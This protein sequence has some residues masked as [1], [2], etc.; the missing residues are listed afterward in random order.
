MRSIH[1]GPITVR[2]DPNDETVAY[3]ANSDDGT[4][5]VV[6]LATNAITD[7]IPVAAGPWGLAFHPRDGTVYIN[8]F[9]SDTISVIDI[10]TKTVID[11]FAA[12]DGPVDLEIAPIAPCPGDITNDGNVDVLDL[13]LLL[14]LWGEAC[15]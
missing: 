10:A 8:S 6:D 14:S 12:G 7:T 13:L 2:F 3:T 5:D 11:S 1:A 4:V 9:D 15:P